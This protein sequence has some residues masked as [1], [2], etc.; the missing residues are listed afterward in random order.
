MYIN[1]PQKWES[2]IS[3]YEVIMP[4]M[5]EDVEHDFDYADGYPMWVGAFCNDC[6]TDITDI[7][8]EAEITQLCEDESV[9][10]VARA[11]DLAVEY[12]EDRRAGLL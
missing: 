3:K 4:C 1:K 9:D 10:M 6:Q 8:N 11:I 2:E 5:H 7:F 12:E